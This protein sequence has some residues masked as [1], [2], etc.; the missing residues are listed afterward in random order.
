[1]GFEASG[2][3]SRIGQVFLSSEA[4]TGINF[5][6]IESKSLDALFANLR[7]A[8]TKV[9]VDE[10]IKKIQE[11]LDS[12]AFFLPISRDRKSVV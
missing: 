6:K 3:L 8:N 1:M 5:A 4:K 10:I 2:R 7:I 9:S 11:Y 12:E